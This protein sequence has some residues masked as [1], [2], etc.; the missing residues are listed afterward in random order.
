MTEGPLHHDKSMSVRIWLEVGHVCEPRRS[1]Q[2]RSLSFD[3]RLW[4]RGVSGKDISSFVH[5]VVFYLHP[6]S[7]FMYPKRVCQEPPY[8]IQE[9]GCASID[10]PIHVYLK[11]SSEPQ[12]IRLQYSLSIE[13]NKSNSS[14]SRC[15]YYDFQNPP[16][17]LR[18][19]LMSGGGEIV[20]RAHRAMRAD[21]V[22]MLSDSRDKPRDMQ[23]K[24]KAKFVEP[25]SCRHSA[26]RVKPYPQDATCPKCGESLDVDFRKQLRG[27]SM[28]KD[29]IA[30]VSQLYESYNLYKKSVDALALPPLSDPIYRVPELPAGLQEA[31]KGVKFDLAL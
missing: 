23:I 28:T 24:K 11:H 2:G 8:E 13:N 4:V 18:R 5:K 15:I 27:V 16:E 25:V 12:K 26:K 20:S 14:E 10:V 1:T 31:L 6:A 29:E 19:A 9:S 7:I 22:I 30:R 21:R 17:Q 3:W